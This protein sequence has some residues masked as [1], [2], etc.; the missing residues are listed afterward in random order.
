MG[1]SPGD[2]VGSF[3]RPSAGATVGSDPGAQP[4]TLVVGPSTDH[5]FNTLRARLIPNACFKLE[6]SNFEFDSSFVTV[7]TFDAGPLKNL[8]DKHPRSK[9]SIFGHADPSGRDDFNKVL[10]GRRAQA[11][12]GLLVRRVDLWEDLYFHHDALTGKDE[13]GVRAIQLMLNQVGP[14]KAGIGGELD[15]RTKQALK[16]FEQKEGLAPKGFNP[17]KEVAA[18]TFRKLTSLYMDRICTDD[19]AQD[20]R[21]KPEDFLAR[22]KGK[23]GKGDFQGCGEFNPLMIFSRDERTVLD[24]AENHQQ[25]N[26]ENQTNRRVMVLLFR[27]GSQVDPAKWPC[28]SAKE[29]IGGCRLRFFS[30]GETR[31]SNQAVRR[32]FQ[33][34]KDTFACR[35]YDRL[36]STSPCEGGARLW[37]IRLLEAGRTPIGQRRPLANLPFSVTGIGGD[38][39]QFLGTTDA[40]GVLRIPVGDDPAVMRLLIAGTELTILGGSLEGIRS[41]DL[42]VFQRLTNLGFGTAVL[43]KPDPVAVTAAIRQFQELHDI[44][45]AE[46]PTPEFRSRLQQLHGS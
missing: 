39:R 41:A 31:R 28:P 17:K 19:A 44:P 24:R 34:T 8:L 20:F 36:N 29:G 35:F 22:G 6:D 10:S 30:D 33:R 27:P 32:E 14:T 11:I 42:G 37:V 45:V 21:L 43:E 15:E 16:D 23:D 2:P 12:F 7:V 18:E 38:I 4:E 25:R 1:A 46:A 9:L 40:N 3:Q 13:W 26:S 5:E